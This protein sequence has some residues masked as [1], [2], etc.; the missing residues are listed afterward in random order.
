[1]LDSRKLLLGVLCCLNVACAGLSDSALQAARNPQTWVPV[2]AAV[3]I[4]ATEL[5]NQ[6]ADDAFQDS[7]VFH[8]PQGSSDDLRDALTAG[9]LASSFFIAGDETARH[10]LTRLGFNLGGL[11]GVNLA[12]GAIKELE[13]RERPNGRGKQSFPSGHAATALYLANATRYNIRRL[14]LPVWGDVA[15]NS[16][17]FGA[18]LGS[19]WARIEAGKHHPSDVLTGFAFGHFFANW[20]ELTLRRRQDTALVRFEPLPGGGVLRLGVSLD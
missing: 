13:L 6:I 12:V 20:I 11:A 7:P 2:A 19:G 8:D 4:G 17:L 1:M 10:R 5:D 16:W 9:Y 3:V 18:A 14:D 15:F